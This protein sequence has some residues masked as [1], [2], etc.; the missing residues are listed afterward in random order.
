[1]RAGRVRQR[2]QVSI[3]IVRARFPNALTTP[4]NQIVITDKLIAMADNPDEV[5]GVLSHEIGHVELNHVMSNVVRNIGAG[6]FFD[7]VFGGGGLGQAVAITSVQL[8][9]LSFSR[10]DELAADKR[11]MDYMDAAG[12]NPGAIASLFDRFAQAQESGA[13]H[14]GMGALL[15][16][17]P[18]TAERAALA[19][20]RARAGRASSLTANEW[21]IVQR[22]CGGTT[23]RDPGPHASHAAATRRRPAL[24]PRAPPNPEMPHR[25]HLPMPGD[26]G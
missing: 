2:D 9:G 8:S 16:N 22:A 12:I 19:R 24:H 7:V 11:G 14:R 25:A 21:Q 26:A 10:D 1:M 6:V 15:A 17:H 13:S 20:S 3:T 4:D 23:T 5:A 18:P